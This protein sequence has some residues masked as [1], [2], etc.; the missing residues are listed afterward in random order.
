MRKRLCSVCFT[1]ARFVSVEDVPVCVLK[2]D[3]TVLRGVMPVSTFFCAV[4][5]DGE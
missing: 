2:L 4:H 3:G 5:I 1:R